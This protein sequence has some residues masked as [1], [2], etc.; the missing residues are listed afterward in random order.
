MGHTRT[1][2]YLHA[3]AFAQSELK[4]GNIIAYSSSYGRDTGRVI[5]VET[6]QGWNPEPFWQEFEDGLYSEHSQ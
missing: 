6:A 5:H 1:L 3:Q 2:A 4:A